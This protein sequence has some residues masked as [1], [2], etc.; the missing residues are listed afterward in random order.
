MSIIHY[1]SRN[2][3]KRAKFIFN[4]IAPLY[5]KLDNKLQEGFKASSVV[6]DKEIMITGK[7]VLDIGA[8]T[9]AW[10]AAINKLGASNV[11]GVDFSEKMLKQAKKN[12][13]NINFS[14]GD[15]ENL[16][17]FKDNSIDIVTASFVLHGVKFNKRERMLD[18]M[19][20]ISK[21]YIVL[22]DF[23]GRTPLFIRFLEFMENSDYKNFKKN[24]C[25]ELQEKFPKTRKIPSRFGS[26]LYIAEI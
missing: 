14:L 7:S 6:L 26:G 5:G 19:K 21:R 10:G 3:D 20:R 15:A 4:F 18:E 8:G 1:F 9:G 24:F 13:P 25:K 22:H 2:P 16:S 17:E 23:I 12:H 11:H